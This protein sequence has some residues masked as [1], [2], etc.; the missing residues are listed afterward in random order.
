MKTRFTA[1]LPTIFYNWSTLIYFELLYK[2]VGFSIVF[3]LLRFIA[4]LIL[5]I[6]GVSF[7]DHRTLFLIFRHPLAVCSLF[8]ALLL[9]ILY[10]FFELAAYIYYCDTNWHRTRLPLRSLLGGAFARCIRFFHYKNIFAVCLIPL[11]L[12]TAFPITSA[13]LNSFQLPEYI[14]SFI[15]ENHLRTII[16]VVF[17]L[18]ANILMLHHLFVLPIMVVQQQSFRSSRKM[19]RQLLGGNKLRSL[20]ILLIAAAAYILTAILLFLLYNL[21]IGGY[22][23]LLYSTNEG[24]YLFR[25]MYDSHL[26]IIRL[27][28]STFFSV[29]LIA[30]LINLYYRYQDRQPPRPAAKKISAVYL[31]K[32]TAALIILIFVMLLFSETELAGYF[33]SPSASEPINV[34][35]HRGGSLYAP[36]N[37]VAALEQ[38]INDRADIAEIDIQQTNDGVLVAL[39]DTNL[40][41]IA[42]INRDISEL[43]YADIRHVD[44]GSHFSPQFKNESI[45]TLAQILD[46]AKNRV[47]LILEL[48]SPGY[49]ADT[50]RLIRQFGMDKQ[51]TI[52]SMNPEI[53]KTVKKISPA[54]KTLYTTA[55][56]IPDSYTVEYIDGFSIETTF[57]TK[58]IVFS[59]HI[60]GKSIYAWTA[61]ER[62]NI[63]KILSNEA[64]GIITDNVP[65]VHACQTELGR[66]YLFDYFLRLFYA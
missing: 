35:A 54:V 48:K 28:H 44:A 30:V 50:L 60:Q 3:P 46:C 27:I 2:A 5:T 23:K 4:S 62:S 24:R 63:Q 10:L 9:F 43:S 58:E 19:N 64:D 21:F 15:T 22:T 38:A 65:L 18:S 49:E 66:G 25:R 17:L 32:K 1:I 14:S 55:V 36:E 6:V 11:M 42:N 47:D 52:T 56:F 7:L 13:L 39:H 31:M 37:T 61:N 16:Y 29:T 34:V 45:P 33:P 41:R 20:S 59:A 57:L 40:K 26:R 51:C 12:F 53:L 8:F